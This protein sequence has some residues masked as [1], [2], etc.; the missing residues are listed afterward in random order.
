M[1]TSA[2]GLGTNNNYAG[3]GQQNFSS[4]LAFEGLMLSV[5]IFYFI[6]EE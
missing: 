4:Q 5:Q 2:V 3:E 6:T 1:T